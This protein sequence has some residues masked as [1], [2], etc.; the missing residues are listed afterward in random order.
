[1]GTGEAESGVN[2]E[3]ERISFWNGNYELASG[4]LFLLFN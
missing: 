2:G 4:T 3:K 1:L